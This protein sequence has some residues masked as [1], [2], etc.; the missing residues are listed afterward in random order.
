[1]FSPRLSRCMRLAVASATAAL[2][3]SAT[4]FAQGAAP[5]KRPAVAGKYDGMAHGASQG[6]IAMTVT[7]AQTGATFTGTMDA[8]Q[9]SFSIYDGK[10]EGDK[11]MW[12]FSNGEVNG[13]VTAEY[14][15]GA[16]TGEWSASSEGGSI[17]L[18]KQQ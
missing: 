13:G 7:L 1:M 8:G 17:E 2:L 9:M 5:A 3:V 10:I 4:L 12:S 16:I 6:D 15:D 18:K 14:R 11:L